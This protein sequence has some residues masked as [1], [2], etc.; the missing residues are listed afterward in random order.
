MPV[1]EI[2]DPRLQQLFGAKDPRTAG[3]R[4]IVRL[5]RKG[6]PP[7]AFAA[8][9]AALAAILF[10]ALEARRTSEAAPAV[11]AGAMDTAGD[12]WS[13]PPPLQIPPAGA[14]AAIPLGME[15]P[16]TPRLVGPAP[17]PVGSR[18]AAAPQF[19]RPAQAYP[20]TA[21]LPPPPPPPLAGSGAPLAIDNVA[22]PSGQPPVLGVTPFPAA[23]E[24]PSGDRVRASG[25]ANRSMT[26]AQG[27]LIPAVLE[28]GLDSTKPGFVRAI[29]SRDVR[30]F[31]GKNVLIPRGS[32]LIGEYKSAV[33]RDQNRA[34]ITWSRLVRPDGITIDLDSPGTD[35]VGRGGVAASANSHFLA[36]FAD[37][38]VRLTTDVGRAIA[39][40]ALA[41]PLVLLPGNN[42]AS[43]LSG[44]PARVPT[45]KVP[46]GRSISV[47]V[48]H[49]L[50]FSAAGAGS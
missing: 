11:R 39:S 43:Q 37:K 28:T 5:P 17:A 2:G 34:I 21:W 6:V 35:I 1:T 30:G 47:F 19:F 48:A 25:I 36:S 26:V 10:T 4:P 3:V 16:G 24:L 29:V 33:A 32:H 20:Q 42:G 23:S 50:D 44:P 14:P 31:D 12:P 18:R 49:D 15:R 40:G 7:L 45:L 38:V 27:S 46:P 8:S 22:G 41:G 9:A 13:A